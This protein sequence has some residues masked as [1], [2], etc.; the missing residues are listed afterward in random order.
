MDNIL[1]VIPARGGSK[2]LP[3]KNIRRLH[4]KP[5]IHY[6]I[7]YA[8]SIFADEQI[9]VS[10]DSK[11]IK[12]VAEETNLYIPFLRPDYLA[13]DTAGT[14][15]VLLHAVEYYR[16]LGRSIEIVVLLQPTS[17]LREKNHII[18][19]FALYNK[20]LDMVVSVKETDSNPYYVLFEE[21]KNGFLV[22]SKKG[23]FTRRQDCPKVWEFNGSIYIINVA[24]LEEKKMTQF[25]KI[26]PYEMTRHYSHDID[27]IEDFEYL[28]FLAK[29]N[30]S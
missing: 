28:E 17:P 25:E 9:C 16:S 7:D 27:T 23:N 14:R 13:T 22:K 5:L 11:E 15:E 20:S 12:R 19:A 26:I 18:E 4:G 10:T 6:S 24:S 2:G 8:R 29:K 1:V 30:H 21:N 3:G